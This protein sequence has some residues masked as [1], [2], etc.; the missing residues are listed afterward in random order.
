ME[1]DMQNNAMYARVLD[2]ST[3]LEEI[4][5]DEDS[6]SDGLSVISDEEGDFGGDF[7]SDDARSTSQS[8][9]HDDDGVA[10]ASNGDSGSDSDDND[11]AIAAP[12]QPRP[13]Q[14]RTIAIDPHISAYRENQTWLDDFTLQN[15]PLI[16]DG[17]SKPG[18]IFDHMLTGDSI[19]GDSDIIGV[20]VT[21]TNRYADKFKTDFPEK[22]A[23]KNWKPID[24][25]TM[26]AFFAIIL[27]MGLMKLPTLAMYWSTHWLLNIGMSDI[28]SRDDFLMIM[29][30]LHCCNNSVAIA[31]GLPGYDRLY[32][33]RKVSSMFVNNWKRCFYPAREISI[34]ECIIGFKGR[35]F[36]K[37]YNPKKPHKWGICVWSVAESKSGYTYAWQIYTGKNE[38]V[39]PSGNGATY[40]IV[41]NILRQNGLLDNNHHVYMD[42]FF[43][44]GLLFN[45]LSKNST[46]AC[47]TLRVNRA[48][49]PR[50]IKDAKQRKGDPPIFAREGRL[51]FI[52]WQDKK[53]VT[54]VS[55]VHNDKTFQ[56]VVKDK[57]APNHQREVI[58][59]NA[60]ELY[61]K[62]MRGVD[63]AD[64]QM[65]HSL[66]DHKSVKWWKKVLFALLETSF[67]NSLIIFMRCHPGVSIDRNKFRLDVI[68]SLLQQ[69][70]RK[71]SKRGRRASNPSPMHVTERH[72]DCPNPTILGNGKR[73]RL[74]CI[75]CIP[76]E[77]KKCRTTNWCPQC[78]VPVH[79][80][81]CFEKLHTLT[82]YK[83]KCEGPGTHD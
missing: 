72:F 7:A 73:Q 60:I 56:K 25:N 6:E 57:T 27:F 22:T 23:A 33:I 3:V 31:R 76:P 52:S 18:E 46:G 13:Q 11:A 20:I 74:E 40:D 4:F 36:L 75:V 59:P 61:T 32:K 44:S 83:Y 79:K 55:S 78:N 17:T 2:S 19:D 1:D 70:Q 48:L 45:E 47:G 68:T 12:A 64:Q 5:A 66:F 65:W 10:D 8:D 42:N 49:T 37:Q 41:I 9:G 63:L 77:G 54:L 50:V 69:Y 21:E 67:V 39:Q 29:K 53:R 24:R 43:S 34:D 26:K 30:F 62:Y 71:P 81:G 58:K 16:H 35:T 28:M 14:Q 82:D 15:G 80:Y 51:Q 38:E